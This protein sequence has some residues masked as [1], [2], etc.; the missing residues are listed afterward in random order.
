LF[1]NKFTKQVNMETTSEKYVQWWSKGKEELEKL[2][3][4]SLIR[5]DVEVIFSDLYISELPCPVIQYTDEEIILEWVEHGKNAVIGVKDGAFHMI[6]PELSSG[7]EI[8]FF[9][10]QLVEFK[11]WF[12]GD[13]SPVH[14]EEFKPSPVPP[15]KGKAPP[16]ENIMSMM[17]NMMKTF[18]LDEMFEEMDR[19]DESLPPPPSLDPMGE[20]FQIILLGVFRFL[21]W[22]V[23]CVSS[24]VRVRSTIKGMMLDTMKDIQEGYWNDILSSP[25]KTIY[26]WSPKVHAC[27]NVIFRGMNMTIRHHLIVVSIVMFFAGYRYASIH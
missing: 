26:E 8:P 15:R 9:P 19:N 22:L 16:T 2:P 5:A 20:F 7:T 13:C 24:K 10:E 4:E 12:A 3:K 6:L 23:S 11:R 27:V 18:K 25:D 17:N 1:D 14:E 21:I